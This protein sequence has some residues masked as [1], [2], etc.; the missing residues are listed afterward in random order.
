MTEPLMDD[1]G[2]ITERGR[3]HVVW[4]C[5]ILYDTLTIAWN[6]HRPSE[7]DLWTDLLPEFMATQV[8]ET[9]A[10]RFVQCFSDI[11]M[12]AQFDGSV[13]PEC[14]GEEVALHLAINELDMIC[15]GMPGPDDEDITTDDIEAMRELLFE[16]QDVLLLF[17]WTSPEAFMETRGDA[18]QND[19]YEM[20]GIG[21]MDYNAW[22][23]PFHP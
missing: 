5:E 9:W 3:K 23:L 18:E 1:K 16:D 10:T 21:R 17:D 7:G 22:F 20:L 2:Q 12:R 8:D 15:D 14:T 13:L 6:Q 19:L 11:K 4:A